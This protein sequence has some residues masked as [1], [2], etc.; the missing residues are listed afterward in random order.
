MQAKRASITGD[1]YVNCTELARRLGISRSTLNRWVE[2][3]KLPKPESAASGCF[4]GAASYWSGRSRICMTRGACG[5]HTC[6]GRG[7]FSSDCW[8]IPARSIWAV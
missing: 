5:G 1:K 3:G 7:I 8:C 4:G 2:A 6:V